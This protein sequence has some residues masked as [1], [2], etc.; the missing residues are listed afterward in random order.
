M[1]AV[2]QR[3]RRASVVVE[4]AVVGQ[5]GCGLLVLLGIENGDTSAEVEYLVRK[6]LLV[7]LFPDEIHQD[8]QA[9]R[10][11]ER[12]V[13]DV[14]G[15]VLVVSQ[16]TLSGQTRKGTR[17]SF[18]RSAPPAVAEPLYQAYVEAVRSSGLT[19]ETGVFGAM[20]SVESVNDGPVTLLLGSSDSPPPWGK[21]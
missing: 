17:P 2:L 10:H 6:T 21:Q 11:F 3:V 18:D 9:R 7:R 12:S 5:I 4:D 16:F 1:L 15:S 19:V 8:G 14:G 20:M 13:V